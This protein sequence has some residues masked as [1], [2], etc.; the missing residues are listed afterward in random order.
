MI[1]SFSFTLNVLGTC[2]V[3]SPC[4]H[5]PRRADCRYSRICLPSSVVASQKKCPDCA[6]TL[7][8]LSLL[9]SMLFFVERRRKLPNQRRC[10]HYA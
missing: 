6:G 4:V 2:G 3:W 7:S 5:L 10:M 9:V 8:R 1:I